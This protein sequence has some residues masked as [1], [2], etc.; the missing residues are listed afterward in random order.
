MGVRLAAEEAPSPPPSLNGG[1]RVT[2]KAMLESESSC[3]T[4][5]HPPPERDPGQFQVCRTAKVGVT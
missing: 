3:S 4:Y 1:M 2:V 5:T